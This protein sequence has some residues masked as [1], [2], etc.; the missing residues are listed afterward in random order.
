LN[1][2]L[3]EYKKAFASDATAVNL[4]DAGFA[5]IAGVISELEEETPPSPDYEDVI[6]NAK[7]TAPE[8]GGRSTFDDVD[9]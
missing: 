3:E 9:Y 5:S 2:A 7:A 4:V 1:S 8:L 6:G